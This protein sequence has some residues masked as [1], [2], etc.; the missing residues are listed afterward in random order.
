V[1]ELNKKRILVI[2]DSLGLQRKDSSE[3]VGL[4]NIWPYILRNEEEV[5]QISLL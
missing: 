5:F 3:N 4:D 1:K 2:N